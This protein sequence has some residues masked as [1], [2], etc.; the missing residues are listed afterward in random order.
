MKNTLGSVKGWVD[1]FLTKHARVR[2]QHR[3]IRYWQ[4]EA[5]L[6][7]GRATYTRGACILVIGANEVAELLKAGIDLR[8]CEGIEA[9]TSLDNGLVMTVYRKFNFTKRKFNRSVKSN[10][11]LRKSES[12]NTLSESVLTIN[13]NQHEYDFAA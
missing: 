10:K 13:N 8:E 1:G 12:W 5:V 3:G 7:Y 6:K 9:V 4:V 2:M 11:S